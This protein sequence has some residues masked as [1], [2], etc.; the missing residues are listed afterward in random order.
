MSKKLLLFTCFIFCALFSFAQTKVVKG[1]VVDE[2]GAGLPGITVLQRGS[3]KGTQT[4]AAG[5]FSL[6]VSESADL[7][8]SSVGFKSNTVNIKGHDFVNVT[9]LRNVTSDE[10]VVVV[11]YQTVKRKDLLA[12]VSSVGAK[13]LKDIPINSAAEALNGRLAGVTAT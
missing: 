8:F 10:E 9:L 7:I 1:K 3:K 5:N 4:D 13:D 12:S 11:G 2:N 6:S